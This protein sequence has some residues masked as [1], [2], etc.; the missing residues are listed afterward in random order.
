ME[1]RT[2]RKPIRVRRDRRQARAAA[3]GWRRPRETGEKKI[4]IAQREMLRRQGREDRQE[5]ARSSDVSHGTHR[6]RRHRRHRRL[7]GRRG[8]PRAA[9]AR[10]RRRGGHDAVGDAV[11][12]SGHVRG[13]HAAAGHHVT[14]RARARMPTSSTSRSPTEIAL[15]LVAP[16]TANVIGKFANGIA[17]DFLTSLYLATQGAG[18]AGARDE[19]ATCWRTRP[20]SGTSDAGGAR[21]AV[22]RARRGVPRLRLDRQ[23]PARRARGHRRGGRAHRCTPHGL[24]AAA[25]GVLVTAGP[26]YEDIDRSAMSAT[27]PAAAWASRLRP[28]RAARR[29]R[30]ARGRSDA[31]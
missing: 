20:C 25:A 17:D 8:V 5:E 21:R 27:D 10:S 28:K 26:T 6:A 12:R 31:P 18:A 14:V 29:A 4:A 9:E 2:E 23:G 7:Q 24:A 1:R 13:D 30:D 22:R 3:A 15:L 19:H 11:R 16:C